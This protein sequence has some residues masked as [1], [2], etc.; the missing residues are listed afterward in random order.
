VPSPGT[1]RPDRLV[2][3]DHPAMATP[4]TST[5]DQAGHAPLPRHATFALRRVSPTQRMGAR[6]AS[7]AASTCAHERRLRRG[8]LRRSECPTRTHS[9]P[10]SRSMDARTSPVK[11]PR[12]LALRSCPPTAPAPQ[13]PCLR[14]IRIGRAHDNVDALRDC[15]LQPIDQGSIPCLTTVHLPVADD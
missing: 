14:E 2:G 1:D 8:E 6:P 13:A 15:A 4:S 5:T 10:T 9:Q 12:L 7:S 3:N 11:A